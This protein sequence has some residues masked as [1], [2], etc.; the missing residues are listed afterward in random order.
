MSRTPILRAVA[1]AFVLAAPS[2]CNKEE[3]APAKQAETK[4]KAPAPEA[5]VEPAPAPAP[6]GPELL[7]PADPNEA[8][9]LGIFVAW[10]GAEGAAEDVARD[11]AAAE[12]HAKELIER[13]RKGEEFRALAAAES[14]EEKT[15][16]KSGGMGTFT[17]ETW[18]EKFAALKEPLFALKVNETASEPVR[19]EMGFIVLQRCLVEK[20]HTR[21]ILIRYKG[22]KNA[23]KKVKRS[24]EDAE[25]LA[26]KIQ[27]E[28]AGGGDFQ[29]LA[30]KHGEDGSAE[31]GG[32]LGP[33]GR[34]M[35]VPAYEEAAFALKKD[36]V[37]QV[38][39]SDFGF[40]VIQRVDGEG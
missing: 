15:K 26:K 4:E 39:E 27:E 29:A 35:F 14:D 8:C 11:E 17:R 9:A 31:K 28:A 34:G 40:H 20:V 5:K 16:A 7:E 33:V 24:K 25:K 23:D 6:K 12:A 19:T 38:I 3:E 32:D 22:A 10:K 1:L 13:V 30:K 18:P 36:E 2:G 21:H 37:S